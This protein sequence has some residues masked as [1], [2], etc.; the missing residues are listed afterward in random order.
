MGSFESFNNSIQEKF[1]GDEKINKDLI[2]LEGSY[3]VQIIH[4][5]LF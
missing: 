3:K 1:E 5:L 2:T 4:E